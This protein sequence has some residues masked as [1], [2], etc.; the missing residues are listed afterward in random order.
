DVRE[1]QRTALLAELILLDLYYRYQTGEPAQVEDYLKRFPEHH[2]SLLR[3]LAREAKPTRAAPGEHPRVAAV[4][5]ED[6]PLPLRF[7]DDELVARLGRGGMGVVYRARHV[8]LD[9]EFALKVLRPRGAA[10]ADAV[11]RFL[12]ERRAAGRLDHPNLIVATDAGEVDGV[13]FL[14]M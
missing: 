5:E 12:R 10:Q 14:V 6:P 2:D 4:R 1:V 13:P 7:G 3:R 8:W 11:A 9:K